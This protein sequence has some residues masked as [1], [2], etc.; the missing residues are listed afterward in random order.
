MVVVRE[1]LAQWGKAIVDRDELARLRLVEKW[2]HKRL[3]AHFGVGRTKVKKE[4]REICKLGRS[5]VGLPQ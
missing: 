4:L 3:Q 2:P 5:H 1:C